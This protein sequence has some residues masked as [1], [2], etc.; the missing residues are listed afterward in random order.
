[1]VEQIDFDTLIQLT[2][3]DTIDL[4]DI[5]QLLQVRGEVVK[6][7]NEASKKY[8][9]KKAQY[10]AE[11]EKELCKLKKKN[12]ELKMKELVLEQ[13]VEEMRRRLLLMLTSRTTD[14]GARFSR[15]PRET[16]IVRPKNCLTTV[17]KRPVQ[18]D[19]LF[20]WIMLIVMIII[21]NT[22]FM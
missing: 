22:F 9:R 13:I 14:D 20:S 1:M 8:R 7:N 18:C 11:L 10:L 21:V 17:E 12:D 3:E 6:K 19:G 2:V 15:Q 4:G 16:V 5:D